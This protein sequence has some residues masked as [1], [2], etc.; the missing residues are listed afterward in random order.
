L[1]I[2]DTADCQSALRLFSQKRIALATGRRIIAIKLPD[3]E[4]L[5][6]NLNAKHTHK[7][8]SEQ[9]VEQAVHYLLGHTTRMNT[10]TPPNTIPP[11]QATAFAHQAAKVSWVCPIIVFVL[12]PLGG[13]VAARVIIELIALLLIIV[14]LVFG[15]IALSGI[16]KHGSKGILAPAIVGI[17]INGLLLFIFIT[18]FLAARARALGHNSAAP[19]PVI[20]MI[21]SQP[22]A[23]AA[24]LWIVE[25]HCYRYA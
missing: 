9:T 19:P 16:R 13:Q 12:V 15:V 18:N 4:W 7:H 5:D 22:P 2:R 3:Q 1:P 17:I 11:P 25:R 8:E 20:V 10:P 14:G 23:P 6:R 24:Q 21:M